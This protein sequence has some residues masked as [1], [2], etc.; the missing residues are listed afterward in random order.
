MTRNKDNNE[1]DDVK[2]ENITDLVRE[3]YCCTRIYSKH[4][5]I[6]LSNI[7]GL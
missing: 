2:T 1:C 6:F 7:G 4:L 3:N 5:A